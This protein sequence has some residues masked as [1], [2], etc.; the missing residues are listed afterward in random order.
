MHHFI[1]NETWQHEEMEREIKDQRAEFTIE[2]RDPTINYD[3]GVWRDDSSPRPCPTR[4]EMDQM[5]EDWMKSM[6][7][8]HECEKR[9]RSVGD[10]ARRCG[11]ACDKM[12]GHDEQH[13]CKE[14]IPYGGMGPDRRV[15]INMIKT[16]A[17]CEDEREGI[18]ERRGV[19][20]SGATHPVRERREEEDMRTMKKCQVTL[21]V[22]EQLEMLMNEQGTVCGEK[23]TI[24]I[25]PTKEV[26][27]IC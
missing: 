11:R 15:R 16:R 4:R 27:T 19:I 9:R 10:L 26:L 3:D 2:D 6:I 13:V 5:R 21:A 23:G 14:C 24:S 12:K 22:E 18:R 25:V 7:C 8:Y 1:G 20:D 17:I